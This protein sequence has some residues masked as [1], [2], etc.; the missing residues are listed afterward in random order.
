[1][2]RHAL[3][4]AREVQRVARVHRDPFEPLLPILEAASPVGEYL[5]IAEEVLRYMP[6]ARRHPRAAAE[7][8]G[9]SCCG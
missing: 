8:A 6:D 2:N 1:M 9:F 5:K 3:S 4:R 7:T